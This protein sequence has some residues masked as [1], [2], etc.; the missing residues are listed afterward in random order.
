MTS[1][2]R[3]N[4]LS[5]SICAAIALVGGCGESDSPAAPEDAM[6]VAARVGSGALY[7]PTNT[8][9]VPASHT[10]VD[11]RWQDNT[12]IETGFELFRSLDGQFGSFALLATTGANVASFA[13]EG[14]SAATSYCY[15]ARA[16]RLTGGSNKYSEFSNTACTVTLAA[17]PPPPPPPPTPSEAASGATVV[18]MNSTTVSLSWTDNSSSESGFRLEY[19]YTGGSVWQLY[20]LAGHGGTTALAPGIPEQEV[21]YRVVAYNVSGEAPPSNTAC[22][23]PAAGPTN[24]VGSRLD[25]ETV[26]FTWTDNSAVEEGYELWLVQM[27]CVG[28]CPAFDPLCDI[29]GICDQETLIDAVGAN[30]TTLSRGNIPGAGTYLNEWIYVVAKRSGGR[31]DQSSNVPVP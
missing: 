21:C 3:F 1:Q 6:V 30:V 26:R 5:A 13:D 24:L 18:P 4:Q 28:G 23:T 2:R 15:R 25:A 19:S 14:L 10:R 8:S 20:G 16:F 17:P 7:R 12:G 29:Y 27:N 9:A 11:V 22:T 31:S